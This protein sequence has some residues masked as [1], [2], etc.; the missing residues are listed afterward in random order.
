MTVPDKHQK[1]SLTIRLDKWLHD[2]IE[3]AAG[4]KTKNEFI[5][6]VLIAHLDT[7]QT[8]QNLT[9]PAP[10]N[11]PPEI[12]KELE[13]KNE[14]IRVLEGRVMDLQSQNGFLVQDHIR[15]SSQLDRLLMPSQ[16]EQK[17]K[18]KTWWHFWKK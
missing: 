15:I 9:N 5:T 16:E 7:P 6:T 2:K 18:G 10:T 17:E 12:L 3:A 14:I 1:I 11:A 13:M 8:H 4:Q